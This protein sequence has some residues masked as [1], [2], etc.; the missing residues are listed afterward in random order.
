MCLLTL[1]YLKAKALA[2]FRARYLGKIAA[3]DGWVRELCRIDVQNVRGRECACVRE[4]RGGRKKE[5]RR[6]QPGET[7]KRR[8]TKMR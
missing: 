2:A 7:K 8:A 5:E 3:Q 1:P 4:E 6:A